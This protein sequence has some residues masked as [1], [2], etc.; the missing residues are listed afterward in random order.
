VKTTE[1]IAL[2]FLRFKLVRPWTHRY[3]A[4]F[5]TGF[6]FIFLHPEFMS[7]FAAFDFDFG[8]LDIS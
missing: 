2:F 3:L 1:L 8:H 4:A 6:I 7:A 5:G